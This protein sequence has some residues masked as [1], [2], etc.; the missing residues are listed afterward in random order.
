MILT[1]ERLFAQRGIGSVSLR[2]IVSESGQRNKSAANYHFGNKQGLIEAI[3]TY[4]MGP[5]DRRRQELLARLDEQDRGGELRD[6]L[7]VL[8]LPLAEQV[9][10]RDGTSWYARFVA[11]LALMPDQDP[12]VFI[13]HRNPGLVSVVERLDRALGHLPAELRAARIWA[14]LGV[15]VQTFADEERRL[16]AGTAALPMDLVAAHLVDEL[17]GLL[18]SPMSAD[19]ARQM[20]QLH[21]ANEPRRPS[22][23]TASKENSGAAPR[24]RA[25][26]G[27]RSRPA[28]ARRKA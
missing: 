9:S 22:R 12:S 8:V 4:R 14:S 2:E 17:E 21:R 25:A 18:R 24:S 28:S 20:R 23:A 16:G 11:Q 6:I 7:E 10:F 15:V 26:S 1:A 19:T 27:T 3:F 5:I 13:S